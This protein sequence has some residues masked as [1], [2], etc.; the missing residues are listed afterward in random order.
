MT[1]SMKDSFGLP[2]RERTAGLKVQIDF[3]ARGGATTPTPPEELATASAEMK[4]DG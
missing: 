4:E 2:W 1:V 3:S